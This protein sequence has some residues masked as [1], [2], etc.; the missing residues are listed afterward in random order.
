MNA[1]KSTLIDAQADVEGKLR[2]KD[3]QILGRFQGEIA[4]TGRLLMG[5]GSKAQATVTADAAE[6]GGEFKGELKV[7]SLVLLE[8]GRI[9]GSVEAQSIAVREGAQLNGS[10]NVGGPPR[11]AAAPSAPISRPAGGMLAG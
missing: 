11:H 2:G 8:K 7:R 3:A 6:I 9:E 1:D 4:L 5:E 10:V